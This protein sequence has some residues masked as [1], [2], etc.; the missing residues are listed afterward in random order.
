MPYQAP[1]VRGPFKAQAKY[2]Q[3]YTRTGW[4]W[5]LLFLRALVCFLSAPGT[6]STCEAQLVARPDGSSPHAL[7]P[8]RSFL[9]AEVDTR[10]RMSH[11]LHGHGTSGN[12]NESPTERLPNKN[13]PLRT[14]EIS[15][16][17]ISTLDQ[18][19]S[20]TRDRVILILGQR[21]GLVTKAS[22]HTQPHPHALPVSQ[23]VQ[24]GWRIHLSASSTLSYHWRGATPQ[25][26][27]TTRF[28]RARR[29]CICDQRHCKLRSIL[30]ILFVKEA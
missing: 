25:S 15:W 26:Y 28:A 2:Q 1:T 17:T 29:Y 18:S 20:A 22:L 5:G 11:P 7:Q 8:A 13:R 19:A 14:V 21:G 4:E 6:L 12:E 10:V 9:F 3:V 30:R 23:L 27:M 16:E 24:S